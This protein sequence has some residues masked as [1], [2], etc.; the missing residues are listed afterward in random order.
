MLEAKAGRD[1][2]VFKQL[3]DEAGREMKKEVGDNVGASSRQLVEE[4]EREL[5]Q[6]IERCLSGL[7]AH[8]R[9]I[10][11]QQTSVE[12]L[13]RGKLSGIVSCWA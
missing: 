6:E 10:A 5:R 1:E 9:L 4:L 8:E 11:E 12:T 7:E 2:E 13:R 3:L